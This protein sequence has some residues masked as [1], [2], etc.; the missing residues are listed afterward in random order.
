MCL[1]EGFLLPF[2]RQNCLIRLI[3]VSRTRET[4]LSQNC[5]DLGQLWQKSIE[6]LKG[7]R[8]NGVTKSEKDRFYFSVHQLETSGRMS[9]FTIELTSRDKVIT[10]LCL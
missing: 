8:P 9:E 2:C 7:T 5:M 4:G 10:E 6:G 1:A 3:E